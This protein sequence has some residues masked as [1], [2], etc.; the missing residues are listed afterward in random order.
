MCWNQTR[1][2]EVTFHNDLYLDAF[3]TDGTMETFTV[4]NDLRGV[5]VYQ[6]L[7]GG[8]DGGEAGVAEI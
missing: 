8:G 6:V 4:R 5:S 2:R 7:V 1:G 3:T